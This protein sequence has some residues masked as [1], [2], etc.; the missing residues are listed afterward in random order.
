[1]SRS[2]KLLVSVAHRAHNGS[3]TRAILSKMQTTVRGGYV[4]WHGR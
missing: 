1:L 2:I 3:T 4:G